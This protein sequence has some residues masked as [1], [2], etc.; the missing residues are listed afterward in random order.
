MKPLKLPSALAKVEGKIEANDWI[1]LPAPGF[2][3]YGK[4]T[5]VDQE[6]GE[7]EVVSSTITTDPTKI[8]PGKGGRGAFRRIK[9]R[10]VPKKARVMVLNRIANPPNPAKAGA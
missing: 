1:H 3:I 8:Q 5:K 10:D 7:V 6:T 2:D 9:M 4:V